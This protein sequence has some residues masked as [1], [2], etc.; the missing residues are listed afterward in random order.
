ME[1][2]SE[3]ATNLLGIHS[4]PE[5]GTSLINWFATIPMTVKLCLICGGRVKEIIFDL[6]RELRPE[7]HRIDREIAIRNFQ[8]NDLIAALENGTISGGDFSYIEEIADEMNKLM[9]SIV[10][11]KCMQSMFS[12]IEYDL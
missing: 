6:R 1:T 5:P 9:R 10:P 3:L 11:L 7:I 12:Y 2:C 4:V 8:I